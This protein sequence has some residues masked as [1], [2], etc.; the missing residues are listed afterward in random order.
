MTALNLDDVL[1]R[2][3]LL[4]GQDGDA[5]PYRPLCADA[6][7]Q[8]ERGE[9]AGCGPEASG[10]LTAAAAA[11]AFYRFALM[12]AG[13]D[14]GSFEAGD[15]R[16]AAGDTNVRPARALWSEAVAAAS[17]YLADLGFLFRKAT[18]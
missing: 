3:S 18:P 7:A 10:P 11:L 4:A 8:V 16:V 1:A 6:A 9:R 2:F 13:R 14:A 5:E 12:Q 15:V 17:P